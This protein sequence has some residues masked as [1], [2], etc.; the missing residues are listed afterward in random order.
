MTRL[1]RIAG[2]NA[3][4]ISSADLFEEQKK[5]SGIKPLLHIFTVINDQLTYIYIELWCLCPV[6]TGSSYRLT[7][8]L[9]NAPDMTQLKMGVKSV[10]GK[11]SVMAS[12]V[13]NTIQVGDDFF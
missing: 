3:L 2:N 12:G 6:S 1:E 13:V 4:A 7:N 8:V 10:A 9:P 5:Q 11:L